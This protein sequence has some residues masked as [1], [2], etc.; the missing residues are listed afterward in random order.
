MSRSYA[1]EVVLKTIFQIG[2]HEGEEDNLYLDYI[3][4]FELKEADLKYTK[5]MIIEILKN[6][7]QIDDVID[8]YL[9]NWDIKR[10]NLIELA[11]L[12]LASFEIMNLK[13]I[14]PP[15][16][17]N[18]AINFTIKYSDQESIK[19]INAVLEKI[20]KFERNLE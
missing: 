6:K 2:F 12:R 20:A 10:L 13:D 18:E 15:V 16:S 7:D 19:Y 1:R 14:P 9:V 17:I 8:A 5:D 11:I 3:K 4:Q